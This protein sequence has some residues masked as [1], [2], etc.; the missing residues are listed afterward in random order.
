MI[1]KQQGTSIETFH[2]LLQHRCFPKVIT[3]KKTKL[4][5]GKEIL[6]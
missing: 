4:Y 3:L 1:Y 2:L 6:K 5:L